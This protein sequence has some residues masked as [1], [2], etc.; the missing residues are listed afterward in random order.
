MKRLSV[1]A[2]GSH[3]G[4]TRNE[5][6][7][8]VGKVNFLYMFP[9]D[10]E[11]FLLAIDENSY[12]E[13]SDFNIEEPRVIPEIIHK[14]IL[15]LLRYYFVTGGLPEV[16]DYFTRTYRKDEKDALEGLRQIQAELVEG[17]RADFSKYSG[18]VNAN[19]IHNVFESIPTQ[20]SAAL[21]E[22]VPKYKFKGVIPGQKGYDRISGPLGWLAKSRLCI[23]SMINFKS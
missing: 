8:P 6:S 20:L 16:V 4:L 17:Y 13:Y 5:E 3:L 9:M 22:E 19:H 2:A 10:F 14:R 12:K 1:I 7:F 15:E 11:E 21:D 18:T 23:K